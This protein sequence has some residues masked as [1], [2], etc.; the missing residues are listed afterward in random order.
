MGNWPYK[1]FTPAEFACKCPR[2]CEAK[3]GTKMDPGFMGD[4]QISREV[5][6]DIMAIVSGLRCAWWNEKCGGE[7]DSA[8]L[9]S[10]DDGFGHAADISCT[11]S[12]QRFTMLG[13][14]RGLFNR[15]G[16]AK[17]FIH[18]DNS[19][20]KNQDVTWVY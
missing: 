17:V 8:H 10:E 6:G 19:S 18:V 7:E 5:Y 9:I 11:R 20:T 15:I 13:V 1:D 3:D 14:L 12:R 2:D 16:I 4:L